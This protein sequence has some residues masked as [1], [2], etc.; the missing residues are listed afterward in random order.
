MLFWSSNAIN[1]VVDST[2]L[3]KGRKMSAATPQ[4][5][6]F[7]S[8]GKRVLPTG[9]KRALRSVAFQMLDLRW[10]LPSNVNVRIQNQSDWAI[11]NEVFVAG[12]YD[13]AILLA[14]ETAK[15]TGELH[16]LDL[17]AN[18]GFFTLRCIEMTRRRDLQDLSLRITAI[19]GNPNTYRQLQARVSSQ[20]NLPL[21]TA[22]NGLVGKRLGA[23]AISNLEFSGQNHV[24]ADN[25][26]Q[27]FLVDYI[28]VEKAVGAGRIG[29][30]KCDIEGAELTFLQNYPRLLEHTEVAVL[31]LHPQQ[32][33]EH[34]CVELLR[35]AGLVNQTAL[36]EKSGLTSVIMASREHQPQACKQKATGAELDA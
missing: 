27:H 31:E 25:T 6:G 5:S 21:F 10:E 33:D 36:A 34:E 8:F 28:D 7:R 9:I 17:G 2:G 16:V 19:E 14:M 12:D 4:S 20:H 18:V 11:Y 3:A 32:C 30:L 29:L 35:R 24:V 15:A 23:A 26:G 13:P 1:R 22:I